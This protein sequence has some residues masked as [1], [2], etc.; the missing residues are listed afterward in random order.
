MLNKKIK[1]TYIFLTIFFSSIIFYA[2][3]ADNRLFEISKNI[4]L[5][6]KLYREVNQ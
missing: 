5:Y 3:S 1:P 6:N 4:Q 2:F